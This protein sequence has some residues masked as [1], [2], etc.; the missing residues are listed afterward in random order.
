M[1]NAV[2]NDAWRLMRS[3]S[4]IGSSTGVEDLCLGVDASRVDE[5]DESLSGEKDLGFWERKNLSSKVRAPL[6]GVS[7]GDTGEGFFAGSGVWGLEG[8][9]I[10]RFCGRD[11][12]LRPVMEIGASSS[13]SNSFLLRVLSGSSSKVEMTRLSTAVFLSRMLLPTLVVVVVFETW[14]K[15]L[16][17]PW[18]TV[19]LGAAPVLRLLVAVGIL[20]I[21]YCYGDGVV[22]KLEWMGKCRFVTATAK[23]WW[24]LWLLGGSDGTWQMRNV[25]EVG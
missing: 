9:S 25:E 4:S 19:F 11:L 16:I 22:A 15:E 10:D 3:S 14:A 2:R 17:P 6:V 18:G 5:N 12:I 7:I 24:W 20:K 13:F 8:W 1:D 23:I 21:Y